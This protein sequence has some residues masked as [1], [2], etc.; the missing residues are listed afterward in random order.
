MAKL[1]I[2]SKQPVFKKRRLMLD[3]YHSFGIRKPIYYISKCLA[4]FEVLFAKP[5]RQGKKIFF[6]E[7]W[8]HLLYPW[9]D[10][11]I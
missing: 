11:V 8:R 9:S 1:K 10:L 4:N 2:Y 5:F 7:E 3:E 6:S